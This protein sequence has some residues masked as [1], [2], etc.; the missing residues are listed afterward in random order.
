MKWLRLHTEAR[1]D[2]KLD[3][4]TDAE[5]RVWFNLLC[6]AGDSPERGTIEYEDMDLLAI[7]VARGDTELLTATLTKLVRLRIV[8]NDDETVSFVNFQKRQYDKPSDTPEA[9]RERKA[10]QRDSATKPDMS[11][12]V[13]PSHA[14][15]TDTDTEPE[16]EKGDNPQ[17]PK[18]QKPNINGFES[19]YRLYPRKE[20]RHAAEKAWRGMTVAERQSATDGLP[21]FLPAFAAC[22]RHFIPLPA[23]WLNQKRWLD[24]ETPPIKTHGKPIAQRDNLP[25]ADEWATGAGWLDENGVASL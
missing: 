25:T 15:Y 6:M 18:V 2:R 3:T 12:P 20:S 16:T 19:W 5:F 14:I 4:L 7:E 22:E 11:R 13:T 9:T 1:S 8:Q 21:R 24:E 17:T 23:T 10:K